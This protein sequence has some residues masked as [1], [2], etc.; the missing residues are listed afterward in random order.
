VTRPQ[1]TGWSSTERQSPD[2]SVEFSQSVRATRP[3]VEL[4]ERGALA[5]GTRY[6][7]EVEAATRRLVRT[8]ARGAELELRLLGRWTLLRFGPPQT[9]VEA[10]GVASRFP[11]AGGV[12]A[13]APGGSITFAQAV[14]PVVELRATIDGFFPRLGGRPG[15]PPWTG[16]L[17]RH[18]QRR[19]HTS[20]SRRYFRR[21]IAEGP[22]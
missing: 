15:G 11:I 16:A 17:Y 8:R 7:E 9:S 2:G 5:L 21:L 6:W 19:I 22:R 12:L 1:L 3:L 18:V 20:V 10:S 4:S 14:E 13:R